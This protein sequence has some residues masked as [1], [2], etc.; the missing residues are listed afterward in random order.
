MRA[1]RAQAGRSAAA[2]VT[3]GGAGRTHLSM[4]TTIFLA[5][6]G[7]CVAHCAGTLL[8]LSQQ[9][10]RQPRARDARTGRPLRIRVDRRRAGRRATDTVR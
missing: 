1:P 3:C 8:G 2:A 5:L 4:G 7:V 6:G 10:V 9:A